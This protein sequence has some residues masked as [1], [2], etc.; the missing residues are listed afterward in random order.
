[1][2][3]GDKSTYKEFVNRGHEIVIEDGWEEVA[4]FIQSWLNENVINMD[5]SNDQLSAA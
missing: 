5:N 3:Y 2:K 4:G 1:M